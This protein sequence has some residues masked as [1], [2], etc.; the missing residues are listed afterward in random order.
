MK[1]TWLWKACPFYIF[2]LHRAIKKEHLQSL[3]VS[4]CVC[5]CDAR[6][7]HGTSICLTLKTPDYTLQCTHPCHVPHW[8]LS[9]TCAMQTPSSACTHRLCFIFFIIQTHEP[10]SYHFRLPGKTHFLSRVFWDKLHQNIQFLHHSGASALLRHSSQLQHD[11]CGVL[12]LILEGE[13]VVNNT[14]RIF[15]VPEKTI[16]LITLEG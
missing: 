14:S 5:V 10:A 11:C 8:A 16:N 1:R 9:N 2:S 3:L 7:N 13:N 12:L 6:E 4:V 15:E